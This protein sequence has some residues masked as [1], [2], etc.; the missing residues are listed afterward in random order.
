M[1][2]Q[3]V[4]GRM[5]KVQ[6]PIAVASFGLGLD[7]AIKPQGKPEALKR[8]AAKLARVVKGAPEV[9]VKVSGS[10]RKPGQV[11]AHMTYITRNGKI[12]AE[13]ERGEKVAGLAELK[14]AFNEWGF[15]ASGTS[16]RKR[17]LTVNIVLSMPEGTNSRAVLNAA[18][19]FAHD[20]F[21]DNHQY[22]LALHTD[23]RQPHVHLAVKAQGFDLTWV[24]R[25]KSDLQEWRETFAEKMRDQGVEAE[26]TPRRARGVVKKARTQPM[27]HL[28]KRP[29]ESTVITAHVEQAIREITETPLVPNPWIAA[30]EAQQRKVREIYRTLHADMRASPEQAAAGAADQ[31]A[32]FLA[33]MPP[34]R[35]AHQERVQTMEA[36]ASQLHEEKGK[37]YGKTARSGPLD[38]GAGGRAPREK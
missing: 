7:G 6:S 22:L 21:A 11:Y 26:A 10:G 36:L 23:T 5:T 29:R 16:T 15:D 19:E 31:L 25:S 20:R 4:G 8:H 30:I 18:R 17:A 3:A 27:H 38:N 9:L 34:I 12:D 35:T 32:G 33:K 1:L 37:Q 24:K 13:N 28:A 2:L 14:E